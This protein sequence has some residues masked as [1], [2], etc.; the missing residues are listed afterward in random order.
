M[1]QSPGA[2]E[3][4]GLDADFSAGKGSDTE[5]PGRVEGAR[6]LQQILCGPKK[7]WEFLPDPGPVDVEQACD[8]NEIPDADHKSIVEDYIRQPTGL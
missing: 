1:Q 3:A 2:A 4:T 7:E 8:E 5:H 6:T